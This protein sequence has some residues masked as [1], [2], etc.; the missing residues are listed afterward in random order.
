MLA[1][2]ISSVLAFFFWK[3][4]HRVQIITC[5]TLAIAQMAF[6]VATG[7]DWMDAGRFLVPVLPALLLCAVLFFAPW[8]RLL[9]V[10][11]FPTVTFLLMDS[12]QFAQKESTGFAVHERISHYRNIFQNRL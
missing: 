9:F 11:I 6:I 10:I 5:C 7:G 4:L 3:H 12:W 1:G 2:L 8:P